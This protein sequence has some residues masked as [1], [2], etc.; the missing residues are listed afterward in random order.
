MVTC[1]V[2][3]ATLRLHGEGGYGSPYSWACT[4]VADPR[5]PETAVLAAAMT[6]PPLSAIPEIA[7]HLVALGFRRVRW[8][9]RREG[10]ARW[11]EFEIGEFL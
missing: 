9:R 2:I 8:E 6:A 11:V 4:V 10:V 1:R 3:V 5:Q 7:A